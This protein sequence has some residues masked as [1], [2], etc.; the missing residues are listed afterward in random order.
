M[1]VGG[2]GQAGQSSGLRI[3]KIQI[4]HR[5]LKKEGKTPLREG[6]FILEGNS[7]KLPAKQTLLIILPCLETEQ[8]AKLCNIFISQYMTLTLCPARLLTLLIAP[9]IVNKRK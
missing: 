1:G 7:K 6:V 4:I 8:N 3:E 2:H 9:D 5:S